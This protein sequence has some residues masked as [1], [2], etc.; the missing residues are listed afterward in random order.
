MFLLAVSPSMKS[1]APIESVVRKP[2]TI[3]QV[4]GNMGA[5]GHVAATGI[6]PMQLMT[7]HS[8]AASVSVVNMSK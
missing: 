2:T 1:Y 8:P 4:T 3:A 7:S 6:N 5:A